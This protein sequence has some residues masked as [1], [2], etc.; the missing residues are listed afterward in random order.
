MISQKV[1][2]QSLR[3]LAVQQPYAMRWSLMNSASPAAVAIGRNIQTRHTAS[4]TK[5][6][7]PT[8]ILAQQRLNRPVAPH[9]SIYQPQITWYG[10]AFNRISGVAVSGVLYLYAT[11]YLAAPL[12][13]WHLESASLVAAFATLPLAA[14]AVIKG[15]VAFPFVYHCLNGLRHLTWDLGRGI[16]NQQVMRTG[17]T[18][19]GLSVVSALYLAFY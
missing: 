12:L 17:W 2:Q 6:S 13:G 14:K 5:T 1:A 18:V 11:A 15:T 19:V 9:I 10:S 8:K 3:R 16:T 4:T 7:D